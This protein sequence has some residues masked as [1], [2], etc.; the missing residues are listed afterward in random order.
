MSQDHPSLQQPG[1][2]DHRSA[3]LTELDT[4]YQAVEAQLDVVR[5]THEIDGSTAKPITRTP[6]QKKFYGSDQCQLAR[7]SLQRLADDDNYTT[8][9]GYLHGSDQPFVE[10]H[11][12]YLSTHPGVNVEGYLSNLRLMTRVRR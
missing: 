11:L 8:T 6:A 4:E 5:S 9:A 2:A 10:R 12:D 7:E 3:R 1:S